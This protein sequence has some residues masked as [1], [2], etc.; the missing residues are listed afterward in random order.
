MEIEEFV[1]K[2]YVERRHTNSLKWDLLEQRFGQPDLLPLWVADMD[3]K[4]SEAIT[5]SLKD[6][7]LHGVYGY[8]F[9]DK[10][11]YSAYSSWMEA[12][13]SFPIKEEWVR[14]STGAVQAI[15]HLLYAFTKENDSVIIQPPVYYPFSEA[16]RDT[17][18]QLVSV[19]LVN[20]DGY[21][22]I[23]FDQFE[24]A[25]IDHSVKLYIHCSP[26]N[27]VGRVWTEEEQAK[28][29][30]ICRKYDVLIISDEIHQD[31]T[32]EREHIPAAN[33]SE[34]AH[35]D[36]LITVNS[37]SKSFNIAGLTHCNIVITDDKLREQYDTFANRMVKSE[38]NI[39]G[40]L[41]T[42]AAYVDGV[43]WMDSLKKVIYHNYEIIRDYFGKFA[44]KIVVSP[45]EGTYLI[46][47]DLRAVVDNNQMVEFIQ[48]KCGIA[49]D[50]GEWFGE[51]YEG[52]IRLNLATKPENIE[53]AVQ[54]IVENLG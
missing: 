43:D 27:P 5:K 53:K 17:K 34:S 36:R 16:V 8:T 38:A 1:D 24:Q 33:V 48:E 32:F 23:D 7:V 37:A 20:N 25:V 42:E 10:S 4:V 35:R 30:A 44:P 11:Y 18:R 13:F 26:H 14:F 12:H 41:A 39:M 28:L 52:F 22:T 15:Y 3:F 31:F 54:A 45:L 49:V 51:G 50:Y 9:A 21:Y 6:R 29:F 2:Y 40:L 19:D 47:V 46:F